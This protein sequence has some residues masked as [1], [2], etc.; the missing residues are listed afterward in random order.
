LLCGSSTGHPT[1]AT[2]H[3]RTDPDTNLETPSRLYNG[4]RAKWF[5]FPRIFA[6]AR[7]LPNALRRVWSGR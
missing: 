7:E 4:S 3:E 6:R 5:V 1:N 2:G